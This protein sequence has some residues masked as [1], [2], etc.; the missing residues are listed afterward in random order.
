MA[1]NS[2]AFPEWFDYARFSKWVQ[3]TRDAR[4]WTQTQLADDA[5]VTQ[6]T[7]GNVEALAKQGA[8]RK[9][10]PTPRNVLS[11]AKALNPAATTFDN[12]R[13]LYADDP[14]IFLDKH[15]ELTWS[16]TTVPD[17]VLELDLTA[18]GG[19]DF[20][21]FRI[22]QVASPLV[23]AV[24]DDLA[25]LRSQWLRDREFAAART[26]PLS[27]DPSFALA[28]IAI[29]RRR[30]EGVW[31]CTYV[32]RVRPCTYYDFLWPNTCLDDSI[33][34]R[35][36]ITT[37]R[38]EFGLS[39][40][41][42]CAIDSIRVAT[43]KLGA[44]V[45]VVTKDKFAVVSMRSLDKAIAPGG[46]HLAVADGM[47]KPDVGDTCPVFPFAVATR[48]LNHEL[49]LV[50]NTN[51][52]GNYDYG[53]SDLKCLGIV[54][55]TLRIQPMLFFYLA[56]KLKFSE[57]Y[58]RWQGARDRPENRNLIPIQW[59]RENAQKLVRGIIQGA[60]PGAG[61]SAPLELRAS[62]NHAQAGFALAAKYDWPLL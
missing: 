23:H 45:V 29:D 22:E 19:V 18:I 12:I 7:V 34:L 2:T 40:P 13:A 15:P 43:L 1:S 6:R 17:C 31:K 4:K 10:L 54:L 62:S 49:G 58:A 26:R 11:I 21:G 9:W 46:Y 38:A 3:S 55:D 35:G 48:G 5:E 44:G 42:L 37:L 53:E 41:R 30:P 52:P 32:L 61:G 16:G 50:V 14:P 59:T 20:T 33:V 27:N 36:G 56:T 47:L 39:S 24:S 57:V 25:S 8:G 28:G 51:C 60:I